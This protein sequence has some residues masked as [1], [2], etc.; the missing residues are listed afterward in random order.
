VFPVHEVNHKDHK[1]HKEN[2]RLLKAST[3]RRRRVAAAPALERDAAG[4]NP[5]QIGSGSFP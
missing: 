5:L 1:G 4:T 2:A 3:G